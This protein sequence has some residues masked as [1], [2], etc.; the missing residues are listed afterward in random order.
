MKHRRQLAAVI[1][2]AMLI[3]G[4]TILKAVEEEN[5]GIVFTGDSQ[6]YFSFNVD[7]NEFSNKFTGMIPGETRSE[8]FTLSNQDDRELRFYI[9][10]SVLSDLTNDNISASGAVYTITLLRD[11]EEFY[12]GIIGGVEGTLKDLNSGN[13]S[14]NQL[15]ASLKKGI[16]GESMNNDY[17]NTVGQLRLE[18]NV[19]QGEVATPDDVVIK[20]E[21]VIYVEKPVKKT[22]EKKKDKT[23]LERIS[24]G[25]TTAVGLLAVIVFISGAAGILI[26]KRKGV[27]QH[28]K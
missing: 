17:Q 23:I 21:N 12:R 19:E 28:E 11:G 1:M 8:E 9:N 25:D 20:K 15:I 2:A 7:K 6:N 18:F 24:T 5:P 22:T 16:D 4:T 14:Q 13:I 26:I 10:A 27:K 3:G